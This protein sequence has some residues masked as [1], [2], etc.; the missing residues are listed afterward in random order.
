[1]GA[2]Y[3]VLTLA[4]C[5]GALALAYGYR[6]STVTAASAMLPSLATVYLAWAS[7]RADRADASGEGSLEQFADELA[8]AVK[9]QWRTE[10]HTRRVHEPYPLPVA[11]S[12]APPDLVEDWAVLTA[13]ATS[14]P[15]HRSNDRAAWARGPGELAGQWEQI[16][17]VLDRRIPTSRLLV[18]GEAGSGKSVLLTHLLQQIA[19][20]RDSARADPVPVL[21]ALASWNPQRQGL[22]DWMARRL[23]RDYPALSHPV[24]ARPGATRARALLEHGLILPLLDGFDELPAEQQPAALDAINHFL[25]PGQGV[26]LSSRSRD[27][28]SAVGRAATKLAGAAGIELQPVLPGPAAAYL[29]RAP[30]DPARWAPVTAHLGSASPVGRA[31]R[32][33]QMLYLARTIHSA[34]AGEQ[35]ENMRPD[36]ARLCDTERFP[37]AHALEQHLLCSFIPAVYL[38]DPHAGAPAFSAPLAHHTLTFLAEHLARTTPASPDIAWWQLPEA[39]PRRPTVLVRWAATA[40]VHALRV[41]APAGLAAALAY[42]LVRAAHEGTWS[43]TPR[44]LTAAGVG[45]ITASLA[46]AATATARLAVRKPPDSRGWMS[47]LIPLSTVRWHWDS[48][49]IALALTCAAVGATAVTVI[50]TGTLGVTLAAPLGVTALIWGGMRTDSADPS[51]ASTP[52]DLLERERSTVLRNGTILATLGAVATAALYAWRVRSDAT[53]SAAILTGATAGTLVGAFAGLLGHLNEL[54]TWSFTTTRHYLAAHHHLPRDLMGFLADAHQHHGVLRQIGGVYQ[55]RHLDLQHALT[56]AADP[57]RQA[58]TLPPA[59]QP[60]HHPPMDPAD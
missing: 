18:L 49:A 21:F 34:R 1:V 45:A 6:L 15:M 22:V 3:L 16:I 44:A 60:P 33:P 43:Q 52:N 55:F 48:A 7:F 41:T 54:A 35:G 39:L 26:V 57:A 32:T 56:T 46:C 37:D 5:G 58:T 12:A 42:S 13:M 20:H 38:P 2:I 23:E 24:T 14:W 25:G 47:G 27:Y 19:H 30:A 9:T 4:G 40:S 53:S 8:D 11:W 28:R 36:P 10:A 17:D 31:L 29:T 51:T 50:L 59:Q